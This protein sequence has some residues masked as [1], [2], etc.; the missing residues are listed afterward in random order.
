[1]LVLILFVTHETSNV[2]GY[3]RLLPGNFVHRAGFIHSGLGK[4]YESKAGW[5]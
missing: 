2:L 4:K 1:M 3:Y 5:K